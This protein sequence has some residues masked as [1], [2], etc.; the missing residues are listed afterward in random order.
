MPRIFISYRRSDTSDLIER[1]TPMLRNHFGEDN[2]TVDVDDFPPGPD[3]RESIIKG[4]LQADA[5]LVLIG[6]RWGYELYMRT[7]Q[8]GPT[9][10][11]DYVVV[12]IET[13][14]REGKDVIPV[15]IGDTPPPQLDELPD[16]IKQLHYC[17]GLRVASGGTQFPPD[18]NR[19][20]QKI[21][22]RLGVFSVPRRGTPE[23]VVYL[24]DNGHWKIQAS[25]DGNQVYR[26]NEDN[27]YRIVVDITSEERVDDYTSEW[28]DKFP[29]PH[30][31]YPVYITRNGEILEK[32]YF[33]SV[34]GA[35]F[36]VPLPNV[37]GTYQSPI[38]FWDVFSLDMKIARHIA[39][40]HHIHPNFE[41]L[42]KVGDIEIRDE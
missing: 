39:E 23:Y 25:V 28:A 21:E 36:F 1:L 3:F 26:C 40:F 6:G 11:P 13:A 41:A 42:A 17:N 18:V 9:S 7:S 8:K 10:E 33:V 2:V 24:L 37:E 5:I 30:R 12:E 22:K 27:E 20:I 14:L 34:W 4:V 16:Q 15:F 38:Y 31:V 19:L 32:T 35:K 29:G